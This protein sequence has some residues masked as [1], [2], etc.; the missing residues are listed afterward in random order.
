[1][2]EARLRKAS[3]AIERAARTQAQLIDDLLD[4][5][6]IVTGK[7]RMDKHPVSLATIV[8]V[9]LEAVAP[10]VE[11]KALE[12]DPHLDDSLPPVSGDPV[13]LQQTVL[14]LLTNAI[15]FTPEGG[16]VTVTVDAVRG[17]GRI[18][19]TDT[20]M[21]IEPEFLP[22]IFNR[23]SQEDHEQTRSH[24]GLGLG[25]AIVRY[26]VEA[27]GGSV[28]AESAGKG[29]GATFTVLLPLMNVSDRP[30][31]DE[32][33]LADPSV[34][35]IKDVRIL[36]VEDDS[37]TREA[38]AEMLGVH[39]AE[40]RAAE[41]AKGAMMEFETF[42]PELLVCD[43]AMPEEDGYTLLRK[44]RARGPTRGGDT[45]ALALTALAGEEDKRHA[46][47][48]GFDMHM[49]KPVDMDRLLRAVSGLIGTR[50]PTEP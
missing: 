11:S 48:A 14:N 10:M 27:H 8:Q 30:A 23:F 45:P 39:G 18:C 19:I 50:P 22:H 24:G 15:K 4:I 13:R 9:A 16:R 35:S 44:I 2:D 20:G 5:S 47:D 34:H 43:V 42:T 25:L 6:R 7:L 29:W 12:L 38:L 3:E 28:K 33:G 31:E 37:G 1:M 36:V 40:V 17:R 26:L 41:S 49:A 21:G 32:G 46:F